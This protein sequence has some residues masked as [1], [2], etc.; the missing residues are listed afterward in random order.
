MKA[1]L[2]PII[3]LSTSLAMAAELKVYKV[4][5]KY[6]VKRTDET[7]IAEVRNQ[8]KNTLTAD[9]TL[10]A[11]EVMDCYR[12]IGPVN[13]AL[14]L[15]RINFAG[16]MKDRLGHEGT[17]NYISPKQGKRIQAFKD[18][19]KQCEESGNIIL[20]VKKSTSNRTLEEFIRIIVIENLGELHALALNLQNPEP[21]MPADSDKP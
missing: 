17:P 10:N 4:I 14:S 18:L 8:W 11:T 9:K 21:K 1:I 16:E 19:A 5:Y 7:W 13:D 3:L 20:K 12:G 6:F 15:A 2:V